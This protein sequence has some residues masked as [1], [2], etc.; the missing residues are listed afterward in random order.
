MPKRGL[1]KSS[2]Y[3]K[4]FHQ[5]YD[6]ISATYHEAG[7]AVIGLLYFFKVYAVE[8]D[9]YQNKKI[10]GFINYDYFVVPSNFDTDL[11]KCFVIGELKVNY[12][13]VVAEKQLLKNICG[14]NISPFFLKWG[15][16][17]DIKSAANLIEEF[18]LAPRGKKRYKFKQKIIKETAK[19]LQKHW[20][21]VTAVANY[22]YLKRHI[23][24]N[25]LKR[26]VCSKAK[27]KKFWKEQFKKIDYIF[28]EKSNLDLDAI[29]LI[30]SS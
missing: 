7:H 1:A 19:D 22:L 18:Q 10:G 3:R 11:L 17:D 2:F 15:A 13:G 8:A 16:K 12:A 4:L 29:R 6:L 25:D 28:S 24:Y 20:D 21:V 27:N 9:L 30:V 14:S 23:N 26:V 5:N